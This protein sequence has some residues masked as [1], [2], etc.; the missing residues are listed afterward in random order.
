[1]KQTKRPR[2]RSC[3]CPKESVSQ[4]RRKKKFEEGEA[5]RTKKT[6]HYITGGV[7]ELILTARGGRKKSGEKTNLQPKCILQTSCY[8]KFSSIQM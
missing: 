3:N 4:M 1:M 8:G 7:L 6:I 5:E 2:W